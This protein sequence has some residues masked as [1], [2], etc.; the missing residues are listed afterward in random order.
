MYD[1]TERPPPMGS[2]R[3]ALFLTIWLRRQEAELYKARILAQGLAQIG[4]NEETFK[5]FKTLS[6]TLFP[7]LGNAKSKDDTQMVETMKREV[8]KGA[9]LF[10]EVNMSPL[11]SAAKRLAVPSDFMRRLHQRPAPRRA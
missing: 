11:K 9:I 5:I 10:N 2:L 8:A 1:K 6:E 4:Q 3:E 7:F